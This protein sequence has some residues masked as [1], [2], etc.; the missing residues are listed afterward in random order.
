MLTVWKYDDVEFSVSMALTFRHFFTNVD[1][2]VS[3]YKWQTAL[4]SNTECKA[5]FTLPLVFS[6]SVTRPIILIT[7]L[8]SIEKVYRR[9]TLKLKIDFE[10]VKWRKFYHRKD[11]LALSCRRL[12]SIHVT[13]SLTSC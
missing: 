3:P 12:S 11:I 6:C 8:S 5:H 7:V 9:F 1:E 13:K 2:P 4:E 10:F